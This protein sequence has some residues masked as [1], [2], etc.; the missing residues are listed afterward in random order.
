MKLNFAHILI[1]AAAMIPVTSYAAAA[2]KDKFDLGKREFESKCALCHGKS[3]KG[4][5]GVTDLL[6]KAPPDLTLLSRKNGGVFPFERVSAVIDGR[7]WIKG[8]GERDMP[9]WGAEYKT[10]SV[11]AAEYYV[12][13]PYDMEMYART[14]ILA[15]IDYLNRLQAK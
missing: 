11:R 1:V 15:L 14:R 9:F 5:G 6:K 3:G 10:E 4:D 2:A 7:E 13:V 8:H 12:D